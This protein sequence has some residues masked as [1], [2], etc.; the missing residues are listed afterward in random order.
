MKFRR[1]T[2]H[3]TAWTAAALML[4]SCS[5]G[6]LGTDEP[7]AG[8]PPK[9]EIEFSSTTSPLT[10]LKQ[11]SV[12]ENP[13][14]YVKI[15]NTNGGEPQYGADQADMMIEELV[16]NG[17]TRLIG[18]YHSKLPTRI[19]HVRSARTTD[20]A[21]SK[22]VNAA[23]IASGSAQKTRDDILGDK[24]PFYVWD[25]R[26]GAGW[27]TDPDKAAPYHVLLD[28]QAMDKALERTATPKQNY[29]TFGAGPGEDDVTKQTTRAAVKFS[30]KTTTRWTYR[31]GTW[32][33][34]P[35]RAAPG[36]EFTADTVVVVFAK[37]VEAGYNDLSGN[38]VPETV[39]EGSGRAV[40]L[41]DGTATEATWNKSSADS[42]MTFTSKAGNSLGLKPGRV[43]L[44]AVP[45]GGDVTY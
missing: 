7:Q 30:S 45:R 34:S 35:E 18:M 10:G 27:S 4:T 33:R 40:I 11:D 23:I 6:S 39:V 43:W 17:A 8:E 16:E 3:A 42:T 5:L 26:D 28:L 25:W 9:G 20:I 13:V 44:E 36:Q 32:H 1:M 15:E 24:I 12:P 31:G 14:Y 19:G 38:P 2:T 21:L 41:S 37:V 22:P 29:F